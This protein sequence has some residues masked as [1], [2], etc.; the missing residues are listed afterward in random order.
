MHSTA[1]LHSDVTSAEVEKP[2]SLS[3]L[4]LKAV[5][6]GT[7]EC[8]LT[9]TAGYQNVAPY[10][11]INFHC[12]RNERPRGFVALLVPCATSANPVVCNLHL[13]L[14]YLS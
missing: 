4:P 5:S 12:H 3:G 14:H 10:S 2:C 11:C 9:F 13:L 6:L 7:G 1:P 8:L